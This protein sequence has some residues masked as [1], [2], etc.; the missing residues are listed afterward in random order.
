MFDEHLLSWLMILA[1]DGEPHWMALSSAWLSVQM[2]TSDVPSCKIQSN[3]MLM[4]LRSFSNGDISCW[5]SGWLH[6]PL[7]HPWWQQNQLHH[8]WN[9]LEPIHLYIVVDKG[10]CVICLI[11]V[12]WRNQFNL[13]TA[14]WDWPRWVYVQIFSFTWGKFFWHRVHDFL[15]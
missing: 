4:A 2:M 13:P 10:W 12:D 9:H 1:A 14:K 3:A 8:P 6:R 15:G 11:E 7:G 5:K